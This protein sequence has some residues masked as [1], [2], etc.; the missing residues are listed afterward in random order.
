MNCRALK[1]KKNKG[2]RWGANENNSEECFLRLKINQNALEGR[3]IRALFDSRAFGS[4]R[5]W[6]C[7]FLS[8][9][10]PL[11]RHVPSC[12]QQN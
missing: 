11:T 1:H 9:F 12:C 2:V 4:A 3:A 7:A 6:G 10:F 8:R 5:L